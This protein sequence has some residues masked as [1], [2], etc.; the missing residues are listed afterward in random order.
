[1]LFNNDIQD[2]EWQQP[3]YFNNQSMT[4]GHIALFKVILFIFFF[5][6]VYSTFILAMTLL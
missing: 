6:K 1:L 5:Y 2:E 3:L 4:D